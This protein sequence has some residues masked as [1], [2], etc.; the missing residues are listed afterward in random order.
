MCGARPSAYDDPPTRSR[1]IPAAGD[2]DFRRGS[3]LRSIVYFMLRAVTGSLD[4]GEKRNPR[5]I[6][7]V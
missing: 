7:K 1:T 2:G 6:A 4:G 5:R 3:R